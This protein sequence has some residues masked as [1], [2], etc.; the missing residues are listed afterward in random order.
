MIVGTIGA[1][2][3]T[4][5]IGPRVPLKKTG[6]RVLSHNVRC[7]SGITAT[8]VSLPKRETQKGF[9]VRGLFHLG[10]LL[11]IFPYTSSLSRMFPHV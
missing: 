7:P 9:E 1:Y 5:I 11:K 8:Q 4:G 10:T 2:V 6:Q 3:G